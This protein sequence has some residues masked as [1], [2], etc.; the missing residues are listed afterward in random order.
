M[1]LRQLT[2]KHLITI[3]YYDLNHR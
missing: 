2:K 1:F 3:D